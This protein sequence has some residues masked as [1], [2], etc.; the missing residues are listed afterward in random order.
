MNKTELM[1]LMQ[2][3]IDSNAQTIAEATV[4]AELSD[5]QRRLILNAIESKTKDCFFRMIDRMKP[6]TKKVAKSSRKK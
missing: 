6:D 5:Q 3:V 2:F 1:D 4:G